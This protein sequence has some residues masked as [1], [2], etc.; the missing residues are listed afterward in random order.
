MH[1]LP[2]GTQIGGAYETGERISS[3]GMGAVYRGR[4]LADGA[5]VALKLL[6]EER[7]ATRLEIE[8]RLLSRLR[9]P[10]VVRVLDHVADERRHCLVMELVR[11][12]S[13]ARVLHERGRLPVPEAVGHVR[14]ACEALAYVHAQRVVHRDV[15]PANLIL[16]GGGV[17][18]VDFGIA[19]EERGGDPG[20]IGIGTPRFMAPEVLAGGMA[21]PR[22]DVFGVGATL[23]T[24]VAGQPPVFLERASL[25]DVV[26]GVDRAVERAVSAALE[27]DP[28]LRLPSVEAFARA[29]GEGLGPDEGAPLGLSVARTSVPP[30]VL[31][32]VVRSAAGVFGAAAASIAFADGEELVYESAWGAGAEEIVGVRLPAGAGIAGAVLAA[33]EPEAIASCREDPRFARAVA[34]RTGYVPNT[35]L[36]V[37]LMRG[38]TAFGVLQVLDRRDGGA[39]RPEDVVR[40]QAFVE[41]A[42]ALL[43]AAGGDT[44][45]AT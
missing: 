34:A 41:L 44:L 19:R 27:P 12:P 25:A 45:I 9:H 38:G 29:L 16:S 15:K 39:F 2:P 43:E 20:T 32:T 10:R 1:D 26:D 4:R 36:A 3:G 40:G 31:E 14:Q 11:G 5:E 37:P 22:S 24:L 42:L 33:G 35:M 7:N 28:Y 6:L 21:S 17:V 23:W 30:P 13:L 18:L 8:A